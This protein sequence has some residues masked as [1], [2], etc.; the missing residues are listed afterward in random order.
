MWTSLIYYDETANSGWSWAIFLKKDFWLFKLNSSPSFIFYK[1]NYDSPKLLTSKQCCPPTNFAPKIDR[2]PKIVDPQNV[3]TQ[4][5][6][7]PQ[8]W[9]TPQKIWLPKYFNPNNFWP[10]S[11]KI[12]WPPQNVWPQIILIPKKCWHS[13]KINTW[14]KLTPKYFWPLPK[15]RS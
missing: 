8:N 5:N 7:E 3:W 13:K 15:K 2:A 9:F 11:E 10:K 12:C 14:K 4:K 6:S 1:E